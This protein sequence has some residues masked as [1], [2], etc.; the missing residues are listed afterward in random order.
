MKGTLCFSFSVQSHNHQSKYNPEQDFPRHLNIVLLHKIK[1]ICAVTVPPGHHQGS[2]KV[3]TWD[4][5]S[6]VQKSDL[7]FKLWGEHGRRQVD[8]SCLF[9]NKTRNTSEHFSGMNPYKVHNF[10][11]T[12]T[13]LLTNCVNT[14]A[15]SLWRTGADV[16]RIKKVLLNNN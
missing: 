10:R 4:R 5:S 1:S 13:S 7:L 3:L 12:S 14:C 9:I 11:E 15:W 2:V 16:W 8:G 6:F